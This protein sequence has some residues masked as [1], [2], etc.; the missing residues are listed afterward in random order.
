MKLNS[1]INYIRKYEKHPFRF[2][3]FLN[4]LVLIIPILLFIKSLLMIRSY[5][6]HGMNGLNELL[7]T[8]L[9]ICLISILM[10][11]F[12][13]I[14]LTQN[15]GFINISTGLT[16]SENKVIAQRVLKKLFK[17][18]GTSKPSNQLIYSY[19][20]ISGFSWGEINTVVCFD[21]N[22]LINSRP[23][24]QP[25]TM[26]ENRLNVKRIRRGII[27]EITPSS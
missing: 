22:I 4:R 12:I 26:F 5:L 2:I 15:Q 16:E 19:S 20:H 11:T 24:G 9:I 3:D 21:R 18:P 1:D 25:I 6:M 17:K 10:I 13:L 14:R 23:T 7:L 27:N 8:S